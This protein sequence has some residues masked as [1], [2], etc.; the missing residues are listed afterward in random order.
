M[1]KSNA[2]HLTVLDSAETALPLLFPRL[3][4][5]Q[6]GSL[7]T[8]LRELERFNQALNLIGPGTLPKAHLVH[9]G[10]ALL[11]ARVLEGKLG[12]SETIY[13]FGSGN[14]I[15]GVVLAAVYPERKFVCVDRDERKLEFIKHVSSAM[16]LANI[17]TL[18]SDVEA[19]GDGKIQ[20][21]VSRGFASIAKTL[22]LSRQVM[23]I[24]GRVLM[25]KSDSWAKELSELPTQT[26]GVW[27]CEPIGKYTIPGI[28]QVGVVVE[29]KRKV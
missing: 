26:F 17:G 20:I 14:G 10:D 28:D 11:C 29:A 1:S 9:V 13:D 19:L 12:S 21:A 18:K 22:L 16:G 8:Y 24:G 27:D 5:A 25:M 2:T 23:A 3:G 6:L 4:A 7:Q 15:P